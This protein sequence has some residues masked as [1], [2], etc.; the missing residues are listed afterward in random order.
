MSDANTH[1]VYGHKI[2]VLFGYFERAATHDT[3]APTGVHQAGYSV[4]ESATGHQ[5]VSQACMP[6]HTHRTAMAW[7]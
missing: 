4:H 6:C 5:V 2:V 7:V 1:H 3:G